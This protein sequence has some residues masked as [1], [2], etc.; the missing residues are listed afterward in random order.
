MNKED[1]QA[2]ADRDYWDSFITNEAREAGWV[3]HGFTYRQVASFLNTSDNRYVN[4]ED[5]VLEILGV[6]A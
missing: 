3:L 4:I 6:S 2:L 1:Q 5:G